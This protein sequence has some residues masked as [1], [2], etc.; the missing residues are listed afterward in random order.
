MFENMIDLMFNNEYDVYVFDTAPT[1]IPVGGV[2]VNMLIDP[3]SVKPDAAE[4]VRNRVAQPMTAG[5]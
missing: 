3:A 5:T 1:A 4:F 2:L